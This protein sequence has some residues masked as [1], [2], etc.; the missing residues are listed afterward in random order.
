MARKKPKLSQLKAPRN[1]LFNHPL[2]NKA[3]TH[4]KTYKAKRRAEKVRIAR[5]GYAQSCFNFKTILNIAVFN[6]AR[7]V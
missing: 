3:H 5:D 4:E 2:M 1:P 6:D 7:F